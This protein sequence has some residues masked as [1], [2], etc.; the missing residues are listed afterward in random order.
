[1]EQE[2]LTLPEHMSSPPVFNGVRVAQS[3]VSYV[4]FCRSLFV[5]FLL[6]IVLSALLRFM[7]SNYIFGIS[8]LFSPKFSKVDVK[9]LPPPLFIEVTV[10]REEIVT[11]YINVVEV[12]MLP[13]FLRCF[14]E[15][16]ELFGMCV[17]FLHFILNFAPHILP[18][19]SL[20]MLL[21]NFAL[22]I[23]Y[24]GSD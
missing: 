14:V 4:V 17:C 19:C 8:K 10:P 21:N 15:L 1:M 12:S 13:L 2:L 22:F 20:Y 11:S 23:D 7:A 18:L 16:L 5:L 24:L 3:L 9:V 6:T